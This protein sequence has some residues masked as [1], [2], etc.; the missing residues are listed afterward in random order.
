MLGPA[1]KC[2]FSASETLIVRMAEDHIEDQLLGFARK[3][4]QRF[5]QIDQ[6]VRTAG[7]QQH[8][9]H[10]RHAEMTTS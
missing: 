5:G 6:F 2:P 3:G 1:K 10:G 9:V 7:F 4:V 8:G